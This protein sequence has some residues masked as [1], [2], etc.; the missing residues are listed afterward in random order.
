M[1]Y[2]KAI[3]NETSDAL[4]LMLIFG[5][6]NYFNL[7]TNQDLTP[8]QLYMFIADFHNEINAW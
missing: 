5:M 6:K 8:G 2:L 7:I 4:P 3:K 1:N